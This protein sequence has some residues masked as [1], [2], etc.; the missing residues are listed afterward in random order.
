[1]LSIV[2]PVLGGLGIFLLGKGAEGKGE[3][4]NAYDLDDIQRA[5]KKYMILQTIFILKMNMKRIV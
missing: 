1:M 2:L 4:G 5:L 3:Y